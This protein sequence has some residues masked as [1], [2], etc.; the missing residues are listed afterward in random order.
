M[1]ESQLGQ[2]ISGA[3]QLV[4]GLALL[5]LFINATL[6]KT[7]RRMQAWDAGLWIADLIGISESLAEL[8][9]EYVQ[10]LAALGGTQEHFEKLMMEALGT[11]GSISIS[12]S[13]YTFVDA[14]IQ[15]AGRA[16]LDDGDYRSGMARRDFGSLII[17]GAMRAHS[18]RMNEPSKDTMFPGI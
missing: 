16:M 7:W 5:Y 12:G 3:V 8:C 18:K 6:V 11:L 2:W 10:R 13:N 14:D 15:A 1:E 17:R 4:V 9:T